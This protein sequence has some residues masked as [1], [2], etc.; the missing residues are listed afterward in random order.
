[1]EVFAGKAVLSQ[2]LINHG[3][4]TATLDVLHWEAYKEDR[5]ASGRPLKCK[6][7]PLD[8]L[9]PSGF[10]SLGFTIS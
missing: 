3:F 6:G 7:N 2:M 8:L 5:L 1:M 9:R 10:A 4:M